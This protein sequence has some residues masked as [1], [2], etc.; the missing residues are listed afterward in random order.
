MLGTAYPAG[1]LL[2]LGTAGDLM[3]PIDREVVQGERVT[4]AAALPAQVAPP[5]ADQV[6]AML[7]AGGE[8]WSALT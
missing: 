6:D 2:A 3:V 1:T 7:L 5:G 8:R 4:P